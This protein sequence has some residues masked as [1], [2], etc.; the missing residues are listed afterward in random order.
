[1]CLCFPGGKNANGSLEKAI[2]WI[3]PEFFFGGEGGFGRGGWTYVLFGL[4]Q[5]QD[6]Q[7]GDPLTSRPRRTAR[8]S[9]G[10]RRGTAPWCWARRGVETPKLTRRRPRGKKSNAMTWVFHELTKI[11]VLHLGDS[12]LNSAF[13]DT[14]ICKSYPGPSAG[15]PLFDPVFG[16]EGSPTKIDYREKRLGTLI[17]SSLLEDLG[18]KK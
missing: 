4:N 5:M 17:L 12:T 3:S 2:Q 6:A 7:L 11:K 9:S 8:W 15:C 18:S 14:K 16:W 10:S 13:G 1:M